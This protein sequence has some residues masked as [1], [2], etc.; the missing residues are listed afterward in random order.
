MNTFDVS[1]LAWIHRAEIILVVSML[2][3]LGP[4]PKWQDSRIVSSLI[5]GVGLL[6][7]LGCGLMESGFT[8][9]GIVVAAAAGLV[10][11]L[12]LPDAAL[13]DEQQ[14]PEAAALILVGVIGA[15]VL[16]GG[17]H[18]L[19]I[20]LGVELLS[21]AG[22]TLVGLS[23]GHK[24]LEAA[25]KYFV[26]TAVSFATLLFGM[27][28]VY[29]ATGKLTITLAGSVAVG[30]RPMMLLGLGLMAVGL[31]FKLAVVPVHFGPLDAYTAGTP[32]VVGFVMVS[33]KLGAA[34]ALGRIAA[35]GGDPLWSFL[36]IAGLLSL[37][38]AVV[39][40]F[41]QTDLRRLLAYSAV[42]HAG[43]LAVA[44]ASEDGARS[45]LFY[46]VTYAGSALLAFACLSGV[47]DDTLP[48][49]RLRPGAGTSLSRWRA[50]GLIVA[51]ASLAGV[52]P[53][54]G[55]WGKLAV[56]QVAW[57]TWG[58]WPTLLTALAGVMGIIY[59]LRPV[60]DL[61]AHAKQNQA[62]RG[63]TNLAIAVCIVAVVAVG[64]APG[65]FWSVLK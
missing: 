57:R 33:S 7:A 10:A 64:I 1:S 49:A 21:V 47:E 42:A 55:F 40:S 5:G 15:I 2:V 45:A 48:L 6:A 20:A 27:A 65:W 22:A 29:F 52:P 54:P 43:F 18:L 59:Y 3:L 56:L 53:F 39:G 14:R 25:F 62:S 9:V 11:M 60:P 35:A 4:A 26:L 30:M 46:V 44:L 63:T 23:R 13:F 32:S 8:R 31:L 28:V 19:E 24:P 12:L 41:A 17:R 50:I 38:V 58:M 36:L 37:A 34:V 61:L 16:S 51:L